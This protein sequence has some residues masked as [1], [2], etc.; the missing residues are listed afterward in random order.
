M[1]LYDDTSL[2]GQETKDRTSRSQGA[3][4]PDRPGARAGHTQETGTK[5]RL[6]TYIISLIGAPCHATH[7]MQWH[8]M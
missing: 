7:V 6:I 2:M 3:R 8:I 1:S 5:I 4:G